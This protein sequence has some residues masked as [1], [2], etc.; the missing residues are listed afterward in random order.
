MIQG[1]AHKKL[2]ITSDARQLE[3][4]QDRYELLSVVGGRNAE[5]GVY[6]GK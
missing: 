3:P 5:I 2:I 1:V 4:V 6:W